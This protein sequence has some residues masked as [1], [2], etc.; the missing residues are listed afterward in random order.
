VS[1]F[2]RRKS[3]PVP[4]A[5]ANV[6]ACNHWER[7]NVLFERIIGP[8]PMRPHYLWCLL[9]VAGIARYLGYER[10]GALELG[11]AGGNGLVA[12]EV[13]AGPVEE[14]LGVEIE[15]HGFDAGTGMPA[16]AGAA[17]APYLIEPGHFPMDVERLRAR[18][19]RTELHLGPVGETVRVFLARPV[20]PVGFVVQDLDYHSSTSDALALFDGP[21]ERFL[22][23]V[24][25]YYD[26]VLGYPWAV[27]NGERL[28]NA[29]FNA[30]HSARRIDELRGMAWSVPAAHRHDPWPEA[31]HLVHVLDHPRY[32]EYEGTA[33]STRLDLA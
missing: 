25:S 17:D 23:R 12:L 30:T 21:A 1:P 3:P 27:G 10:F 4:G 7:T 31:L 26:D 28:A 14:A 5:A 32:A 20:A 9:H 18:L 19:R 24:L 22:P 15:L 16:P 13:A 8:A 6:D 2:G 29:E 11:C 33:I